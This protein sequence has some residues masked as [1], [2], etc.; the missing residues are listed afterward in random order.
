M[1]LSYRASELFALSS[2]DLSPPL[3][4][5]FVNYWA[6]VIPKFSGDTDFYF[7]ASL[8][9]YSVFVL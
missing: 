2:F 8:V 6:R 3:M 4:F 5:N 1:L 7:D 9:V